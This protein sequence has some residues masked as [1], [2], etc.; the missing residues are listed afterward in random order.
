[1][2]GLEQLEPPL[3]CFL[4][5]W[6]FS[7]QNLFLC[8]P[9][10]VSSGEASLSTCMLMFVGQLVSIPNLSNFTAIGCLSSSVCCFPL[11]IAVKLDVS[12]AAVSCSNCFTALRQLLVWEKCLLLSDEHQNEQLL[13]VRQICQSF[14][15]CLLQSAESHWKLTFWWRSPAGLPSS[16]GANIKF[17]QPGAWA[18]CGL[19]YLF[20]KP[21]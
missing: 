6:T 1:M 20:P 7:F 16:A 8:V 15:N 2:L 18:E 9:L 12:V 11:N 19:F 5:F 13:L 4:S 17:F 14:C 3:S 10:E 21:R